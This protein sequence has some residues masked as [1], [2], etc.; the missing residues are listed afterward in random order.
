MKHS[1]SFF[2]GRHKVFNICLFPFPSLS[3]PNLPPLKQHWKIIHCHCLTDLEKFSLPQSYFQGLPWTFELS[4]E[5]IAFQ[6]RSCDLIYS[7]QCK[8]LAHAFT[9]V[10]HTICLLNILT[11]DWPIGWSH[12][13]HERRFLTGGWAWIQHG[14]DGWAVGNK[15]F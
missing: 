6:V 2:P 7:E 3:F 4:K 15:H 5:Y 1:S 10:S 14:L 8:S 13:L 11:Q 9:L 12:W